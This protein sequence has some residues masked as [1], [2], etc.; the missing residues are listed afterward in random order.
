MNEKL[1]QAIW[2]NRMLPPSMKTE[3]GDEIVVYHP[4]MHNYDGG[5][6]FINARIRIGET[7]WAGNVEIHINSSDWFR[8]GHHLDNAYDN[9]ILHVVFR[10]DLTGSEPGPVPFPTLVLEGLI[11]DEL[12]NRY[13]LLEE[14]RF[15]IP[16]ESLL[17]G[18]TDDFSLILPALVTENLE[19]KAKSIRVMW[20]QS[21]CDWDETAWQLL[22]RG[23]GLKI[24]TLPFEMLSGITPLR[25]IR[26]EYST[27]F[28]L[29]ALLFGQAG[30]LDQDFKEQYPGR[31]KR[32]Y[33]YLKKLYSLEPLKPGVWKFLRLR[34]GNFPTVRIAQLAAFL[35]K[36]GPDPSW[37]FELPDLGSL[38][39]LLLARAS[40]YW[41]DHYLFDRPARNL[42][43]I[44]GSGFSNLLILNVVIPLRFFRL[45]ERGMYEEANRVISIM[46][47][48][49]PEENSEI[50]EW[51]SLGIDPA[52][53]METQAL[54]F[55]RKEYC[56]KKRCLDCRIGYR[57]L[58]EVVK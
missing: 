17:K 34:P 21:L 28:R 19:M 3:T 47:D 13:K 18:N 10:D 42:P 45:R 40:E 37:I 22:N 27:L 24:N 30:M 48:M 46:E 54:G 5:P 2:K 41:D 16:C 50:R 4:G 32:E 23:F 38:R 43:K 12:L 20:E 35:H 31:L 53:A 36:T 26:K 8:H 15:S 1:L 25:L 14:N 39:E 7:T 55:L 9:V 11:P 49:P 29:E 33:G 6:D 52:N 51:K 56:N 57:L 58:K 44:T